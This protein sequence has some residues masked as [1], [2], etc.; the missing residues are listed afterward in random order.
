MG[1]PELH[2]HL[3]SD[4]GRTSAY[5]AAIQQVAPGRRVLDIG[6]GS[7]ILACFAARAGATRVYAIE[8]TEMI[9]VA[10]AVAATNGLADRIEFI[11]GDATQTRL[12]ERVD[13]VLSELLSNDLFGQRL[14]PVLTDARSRLLEPGGVMIPRAV[15]LLVAGVESERIRR[16]DERRLDDL[17]DHLGQR[18]ELDLAPLLVALRTRDSSSDSYVHDVAEGPDN[19]L[20]EPATVWTHDFRRSDVRRGEVVRVP[21]TMVRDGVLNG[22]AAFWTADLDATHTIS[23]AP[24]APRGAWKQVVHRL[25]PRSVAAGERATVG[26]HLDPMADAPLRVL[27][28]W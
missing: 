2:L 17:V 14:I 20:T 6:T 24:D 21:L 26:V 22:V 3:L 12:P 8:R 19:V 16:F 9:D 4:E 11:R 1:D 10:V 13:V 27:S 18:Y 23:T 28:E 5:G 7:G 15:T 25:P